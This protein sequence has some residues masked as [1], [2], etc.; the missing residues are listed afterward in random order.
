MIKAKKQVASDAEVVIKKLEHD[1]QALAKEK[2]GH[3][4]AATN[5][6]RRYEWIAEE[7]Q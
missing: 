5:L 1:L 6:E 7:S 3:V 2:A 4:T